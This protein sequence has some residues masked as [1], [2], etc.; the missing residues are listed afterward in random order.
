[1]GNYRDLPLDRIQDDFEHLLPLGHRQQQA[2]T[3]S[4]ANVKTVHANVQ[5]VPNQFAQAGLA[6]TA[7][8]VKWGHDGRIDS[9]EAP[10]W[11]SY[12]LVRCSSGD[13]R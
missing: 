9:L 11:V 1:M 3:P 13:Q 7:L 10:S 6:D 8:G 2:F 12:L 5:R 4:P